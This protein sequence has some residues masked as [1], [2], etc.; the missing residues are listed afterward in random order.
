V[1]ALPVSQPLQWDKG[2][3]RKHSGREQHCLQVL[4]VLA[5]CQIAVPPA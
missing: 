4:I 2:G 5:V 3:A 1:L